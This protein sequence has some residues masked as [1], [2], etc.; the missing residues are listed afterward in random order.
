M[1]KLMWYT[2]GFGLSC[3]CCVQWLWSVNCIP[4]VLFLFILSGIC[5]YI[6]HAHRLFRVFGMI[7]FGFCGAILWFMLFGFF[8]IQP[9]MFLDGAQVPLQITA[10]T[11]SEQTKYSNAFDGITKLDGKLYKLRVYYTTDE[12]ISPEDTLAGDFRI[13]ISTPGGIRESSY[14]RGNG[15]YLIASQRGESKLSTPQKRTVFSLPQRLAQEAKKNLA[16]VFQEEEFA[17]AKALLLGDTDDLSYETDTALKVSGIRHIAAV[18]GLH[19]SIIFA[20]IAFLLHRNRILMPLVSIPVLFLFAMITGFT[21]SVTRACLMTA[22]MVIGSSILEEYDGLTSLAFACLIM[23]HINPYT[24]E[25]VSFQLSVASVAGILLFA[26]SMHHWIIGQLP[27]IKNGSIL[28][29]LS[30][31]FAASVSASFSAQLLTI[32]LSAY[33]F[34]T[35]SLIGIFTNLM[36]LWLISIIFFGVAFV[37]IFYHWFSWLS[38]TVGLFLNFL[39]RIVL[40]VALQFSRVRFASVYTQ[41]P[42][43][44]CWLIVCYVSLGLFFLLRRRYVK[45]L[46]FTVTAS[47]VLSIAASILQP[48]LDS[49][50]LHV[51][52]VGEGQCILLQSQGHN[53]LIDCGGDDDAITANIAAQTL[54]SQ[55]IHR[56]DGIVLTHYDRDHSGALENLLTRIQVDT[57]YFPLMEDNGFLDRTTVDT[58]NHSIMISELTRFPFGCG[59]VTFSKPG[60]WK[61][62]N[63]NCMCVLFESEKCDILITGDRSRTGEM[64]LLNELEIPDVD[65]LIAGHHGSKNSTSDEL[66]DAVQPDTVIFSVGKNNNYG[67]PAQN[68][69]DRLEDRNCEILRTDLQGS[70]LIRR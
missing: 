3:V 58:D 61:T 37:G 24:V 5:W 42:F 8:Y 45:W 22:V 57:L 4:F 35:I 10:L 59:T 40:F 41:S 38:S 54:L 31:W 29:K 13:R 16:S 44:I 33:Y 1:R 25:S 50:R 64:R 48:G 47:L 12:S 20:V 62:N 60:S 14:D 21:P 15:I 32:P 6:G 39:I 63:E 26:A 67:H 69:L 52:D 7:S 65:I 17:F 30:N 55:G 49:V 27:A 28:R 46:I 70:I 18:S 19:V 11:Y 68:V 9:I 53:L 43:I 66:L 23:L 56:L 2:V 51:L 34:G 36:T